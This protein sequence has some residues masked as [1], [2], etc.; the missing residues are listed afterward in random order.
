MS[1]LHRDLGDATQ[2]FPVLIERRGIADYE[3]F[4]ITGNTQ[5]AFDAHATSAIRFCPQP[6]SG[7][8]RRNT[9]RPDH[10]FAR[11][12]LPCDNDSFAVDLLDVVAQMDFDSELL[13]MELRCLRQTRGKSAKN[14]SSAI[15]QNNSR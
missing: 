5:I 3:N 15:E 14:L 2:R 11:N 8:R 4:R 10:C 6:F 12:S 1:L 7:R 9:S 13:Q